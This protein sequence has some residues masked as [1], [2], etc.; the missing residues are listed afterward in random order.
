MIVCKKNYLQAKAT[1]WILACRMRVST[2]H[3]RAANMG[4][5]LR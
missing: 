4:Y 2:Y 3:S 1:Q 5:L